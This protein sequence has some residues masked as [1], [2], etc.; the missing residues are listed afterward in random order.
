MWFALSRAHQDQTTG[1]RVYWLRKLLLTKMDG[2]DINAHIDTM[3]KYHKRLN[4]LITRENPLTADN[5]HVAALLSSIPQ[6]WLHSASSLM[7]QDGVKSETVVT[8][9]KNEFTRRQLQTK[10]EA[11]VS[12]AKSKQSF[13]NK[14]STK[15]CYFCN[16]DGHKINNCH[17]T[18]QIL[19][20]FKTSR[21][22]DSNQQRQKKPVEKQK[23]PARAGRT[24][25]A[26][27][28][29]S[30]GNPP[31]EEELDYSGLEYEVTAGLAITHSACLSTIP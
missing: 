4:S 7:N 6:D 14:P 16:L 31:S 22:S 25:A 9:L 26:P 1:G 11:S 3:A 17:N 12:S 29:N 24:T 20:E 19:N 8:A 13:S 30:T 21:K 23:H 10:V 2:D 28:T 5:V 18:R 15:H 27:I